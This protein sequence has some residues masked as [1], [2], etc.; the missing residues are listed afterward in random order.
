MDGLLARADGEPDANKRPDLAGLIGRLIRAIRSSRDFDGH[1][2]N[3][4][5]APDALC[6]ASQ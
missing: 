6:R 3:S 1:Q 4:R 5:W 2:S